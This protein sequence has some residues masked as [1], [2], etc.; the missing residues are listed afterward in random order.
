MKKTP[1]ANET[2]LLNRCM[3]YLDEVFFPQ[4]KEMDDAQLES[5]TEKIG[6]KV[7]GDLTLPKWKAACRE[8]LSA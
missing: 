8:Q 2:N 7:K 1:L 6:A 5:L 4:T 3:K